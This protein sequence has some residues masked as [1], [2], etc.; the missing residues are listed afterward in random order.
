MTIK[1]AE[2]FARLVTNAILNRLGD[3]APRW[4]ILAI[5]EVSTTVGPPP[6]DGSPEPRSLRITLGTF[7]AGPDDT[8]AVHFSLDV[9]RQLATLALAEQIQGHVLEETHGNPLPP[10]P[11]HAHPLTPR[12]LSG[13]MAVWSCPSDPAHFEEPIF[14]STGHAAE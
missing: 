10:C 7:D 9:E 4:Q 2:Q 5:D 14:A 6:P 13:N 1:N 8:V 12:L 11:G 3:Q